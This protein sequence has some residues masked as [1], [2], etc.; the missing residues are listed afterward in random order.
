VVG[1]AASHSLGSHGLPAA[2]QVLLMLPARQRS[3][4]DRLKQHLQEVRRLTTT[5]HGLGREVGGGLLAGEAGVC[6]AGVLAG[7]SSRSGR[8]S[9]EGWGMSWEGRRAAA[10]VAG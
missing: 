4:L 1:A 2:G 5:M 6:A 3:E 10:C 8:S 7:C 9:C